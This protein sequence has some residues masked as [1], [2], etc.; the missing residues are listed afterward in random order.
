M[1]K[2][3]IFFSIIFISIFLFSG[4]STAANLKNNH[5]NLVNINHE[6]VNGFSHVYVKSN[7]GI[8]NLTKNHLKVQGHMY[9]SPPRVID[10]IPDSQSLNIRTTKLIKISFSRLIFNANH[11]L[12][13]LRTGRGV[14]VPTILSIRYNTLYIDHAPFKKLHTYVLILKPYCLTDR[15]GNGFKSI[16]MFKFKTGVNDLNFK[17]RL[18]VPKLGLN[19]LIR[20]DTYSAYNAVYHYPNSAYFGAPGECAIIGHRTTWSAPLR[21]IDQLTRND[22]II[23]KDYTDNKICTYSFMYAEVKMNYQLKRHF[24]HYGPGTLILK[25]CSPVGQSYAK[26]ITYSKLLSTVSIN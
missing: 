17:A 5:V 24:K 23:I 18:I 16:Y 20:S 3:F 11:G 7:S 2:Y 25:S 14:I 15:S 13:Q 8:K 10:T 12:I 26:Y 1:K 6:K 9:L 22:L 4:L 21:H 19:A